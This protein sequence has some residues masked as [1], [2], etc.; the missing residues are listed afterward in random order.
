MVSSA[1]H[2]KPRMEQGFSEVFLIQPRCSREFLYDDMIL[3]FV[4]WMK[5]RL[6]LRSRVELGA[7]NIY[8]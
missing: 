3:K 7:E 4:I 1:I 6:E 2:T 8:V 5:G